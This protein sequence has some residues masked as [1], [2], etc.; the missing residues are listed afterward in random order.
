MAGSRK[1]KINKKG[2]FNL[3]VGL[4]FFGF[5]AIAIAGALYLIDGIANVGASLNIDLLNRLIK[6]F[7]ELCL[8]G[9]FAIVTIGI[10]L[11]NQQGLLRTRFLMSMLA[12]VF[13]IAFYI[14]FNVSI[15]N[16]FTVA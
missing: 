9:G 5:I 11:K 2:E 12:I 10:Y 3:G 7:A 6:D 4:N 16:A 8:I 1:L 14:V 13:A 15:D